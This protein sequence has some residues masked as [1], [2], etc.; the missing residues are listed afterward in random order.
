MHTDCDATNPRKACRRAAWPSIVRHYVLER[1]SGTPARCAERAGQ[2]ANSVVGLRCR[3][4]FLDPSLR[5]SI[6]TRR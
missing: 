2:I 5:P 4:S 6:H 1:R 3:H